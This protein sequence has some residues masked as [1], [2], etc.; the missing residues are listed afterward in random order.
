M[1][2]N[3]DLEKNAW[4]S[5]IPEDYRES[6]INKYL[7]MGYIMSTLC[8]Q[9][10]NPMNTLFDPIINKVKD[11]SNHNE[12]TLRS[13]EGNI[14]EN[15]GSLR[16]TID[17]FIYQSANSALKGKI[18]EQQVSQILHDHF[19]DDVIEV[20]A[21]KEYES[22]I[23]LTTAEGMQLYIEVKMYKTTVSTAQ[24]DKFKRDIQR[25]GIKVG[26][27]ISTTS[28]IIGKKRLDYE[29]IDDD[30]YIIYLPNSGFEHTPIIWSVLFAKKLV[31]ITSKK[32]T[33][34][35]DILLNCYRNFESV[36]KN[37][38]M[39]KHNIIKIRKN[40]ITNLDD[41]HIESLKIDHMIH[42]ILKECNSYLYN[43][44]HESK[45][46]EFTND[47]ILDFIKELEDRNDKRTMSYRILHE[48]CKNRKFQIYN[49]GDSLQWVIKKNNIPLAETKYTKTKVEL[50]ILDKGIHMQISCNMNEVLDIIL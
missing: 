26:I 32:K 15:M 30:Q 49:N 29:Q 40:I 16:G 21:Q 17:N 43:I 50:N 3:I 39:M 31:M 41:L 22:D 13:I 2:V 36:H 35:M 14:S 6:V 20:T 44:L 9:T 47:S 7:N 4:V 25:N 23:Q 33:I 8:Q 5:K 38:S 12:I 42:N 11:A 19:P 18:G 24:I 10:V 34:D 27:M 37:F 48:Y 46:V 1:L 45:E 28:G